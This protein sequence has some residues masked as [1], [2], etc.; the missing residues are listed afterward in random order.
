MRRNN[1]YK[2]SITVANVTGL[3]GNYL[4]KWER[5]LKR[6]ILKKTYVYYLIYKLIIIIQS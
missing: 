5:A 2:T 1:K 4:N 6:R 3:T